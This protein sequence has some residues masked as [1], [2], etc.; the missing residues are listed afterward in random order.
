MHLS[1]TTYNQAKFLV[2]ILLPAIGTL[3][4]TL[5]EIWGLPAAAQVV[6]SIT[7]I[8]AFLGLALGVSTKRYNES[9]ARFDGDLVVEPG[10]EKDVMRF[11]LNDEPID[12][13]LKD[14]VSFKV[15]RATDDGVAA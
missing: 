11:E 12:L 1:N 13:G 5:S 14:E 3:Y 4:F 15:R 9:D 2:Q 10:A 6:G 8:D 7:A